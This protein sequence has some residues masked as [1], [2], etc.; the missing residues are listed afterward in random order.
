M[1]DGD[2]LL[3]V[4]AVFLLVIGALCLFFSSAKKGHDGE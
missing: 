2:F 4:R 3:F 1:F